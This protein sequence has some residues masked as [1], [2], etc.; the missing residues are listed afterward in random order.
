MEALFI[1]LEVYHMHRSE[2][3]EVSH[4]AKIGES[5]TLKMVVETDG[6]SV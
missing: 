3:L 2:E 1:G 6:L 5:R 4:G